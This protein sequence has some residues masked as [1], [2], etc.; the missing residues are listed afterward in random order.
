MNPRQRRGAL[1][2]VLAVLIGI[3]VFFSVTSYVSG[4]ESQVGAKTTVFTAAKEIEPYTPLS[5]ANLRPIEVPERW[6]SPTSRLELRQLEGRRVGFRLAPGTVI[7]SDMLLLPTSLDPTEREVAINVNP[8]TGVAGRIRPGDQVDVYAVFGDVSGL[9]KE[10]RILVR[11]IRVVS[12][13][14]RQTVQTNGDDNGIKETDVVPVTLAATAK[15][16]LAITYATNFASEVRL[17]G[18]PTD[19]GLNRTGEPNQY[20]AQDLGGR[21]VP[22]GSQP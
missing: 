7:S 17:V 3:G 4:V 14:G 22:E 19:T 6:T 20:T 10:V 1:F 12:I 11:G 18:L 16:A 21:A 2:M 8:V 9:P 15:Q 13:G 5:A